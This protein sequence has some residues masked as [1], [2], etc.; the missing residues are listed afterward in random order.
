M[1]DSGI[2]CSEDRW[3]IYE[4][5]VYKMLDS[6]IISLKTGGAFRRLEYSIC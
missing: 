2:N 6:G 1:L 5:G 4:P 3:N